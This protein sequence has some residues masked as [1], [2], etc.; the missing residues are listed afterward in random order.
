MK[1]TFLITHKALS[2]WCGA[3]WS[4][5][6]LLKRL[7]L[8]WFVS[9]SSLSV[10]SSEFTITEPIEPFALFRIFL[11]LSLKVSFFL[12]PWFIF[13]DT[14]LDKHFL[15]IK[16]FTWIIWLLKN[17]LILSIVSWPILRIFLLLFLF[18]SAFWHAQHFSFLMF[19]LFLL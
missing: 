11:F 1:T 6:F 14:D 13:P 4:S 8:I 15:H 19:G 5:I 9:D 16:S 3:A 7:F 2:F 12:L 10:N 18:R 17:V